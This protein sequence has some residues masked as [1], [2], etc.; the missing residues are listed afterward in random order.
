MRLTDKK[1]EYSYVSDWRSRFVIDSICRHELSI[2]SV[3]VTMT[4]VLGPKLDFWL[5]QRTFLPDSRD[6]LEQVAFSFT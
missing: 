3:S 6:S 1:I 4:Q 5:L 2:G